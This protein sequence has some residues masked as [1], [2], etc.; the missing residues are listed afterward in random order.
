VI[1]QVNVPSEGLSSGYYSPLILAAVIYAALFVANRVLEGRGED[2]RAELV[3]DAGFVVA[4]VSGAY[5]LV[6]FIVALTSEIDLISDMLLITVVVIAF[7]AVLGLL[8]LL[9][10]EY[11]IRGISRTRRRVDR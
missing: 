4:L 7:F 8:L 11:G 5:V 10:F 1:A 3:A 6:L 9:V 2:E